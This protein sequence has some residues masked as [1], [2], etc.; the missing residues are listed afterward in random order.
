MDLIC[1]LRATTPPSG[2]QH[3]YTFTSASSGEPAFERVPAAQ[4]QPRDGQWGGAH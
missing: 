1:E 3:K 4:P 2:P